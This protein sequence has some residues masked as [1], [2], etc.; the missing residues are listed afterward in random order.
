MDTKIALNRVAGLLAL[1]TFTSRQAH[2]K[3]RN[4]KQHV[5]LVERENL[6][7]AETLGIAEKYRLSLRRLGGIE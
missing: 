2:A 5:A 1:S 7:I 4:L 3:T 6:E